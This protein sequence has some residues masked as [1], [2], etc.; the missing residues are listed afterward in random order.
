MR[1][2]LISS[3]SHNTFTGPWNTIHYT[4]PRSSLKWPESSSPVWIREMLILPNNPAQPAAVLAFVIF[5][6]PSLCK[7]L[8]ALCQYS[9]L[10]NL[11]LPTLSRTTFLSA[12][13]L[14]P[15]EPP[16]PNLCSYRQV[17]HI[18]LTFS[19]I[20]I[21]CTSNT[22]YLPSSAYVPTIISTPYPCGLVTAESIQKNKVNVQNNHQPYHHPY[23]I[24]L[25]IADCR[26]HTEEQRR[27]ALHRR[28][29]DSLL[30]IALNIPGNIYI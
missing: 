5:Q 7:L 23:P 19:N 14:L 24:P 28:N 26:V 4:F 13:Q 22:Y 2:K 15:G 27:P 25:W 29:I 1:W 18:L 20:I 9:V 11:I 8:T 21:Q 3:F 17:N 12:P 30:M 16:S 6:S 10:S